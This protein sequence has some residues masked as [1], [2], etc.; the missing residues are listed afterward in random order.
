MTSLRDQ[1]EAEFENIERVLAEFPDGQPFSA[2]STLELAGVSTLLHNFYN[3]LENILKYIVQSRELDVPD[4][5]SWHRDL[6]NIA[7]AENLITG[8]TAEALKPYL[9]FRHFF[10]HAYVMDLQV[11]R[12][13]PLN[14]QARGVY[15][16]FRNDIEELLSA[17]SDSPQ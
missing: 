8:A 6:V 2:L 7:I 10:V 15:E 4:G 3:G 13:R 16:S 14:E 9:A 5:A 12:L 1:V 11:E 17:S